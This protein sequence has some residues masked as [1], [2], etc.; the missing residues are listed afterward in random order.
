MSVFKLTNMYSI[1][2]LERICVFQI[3]V[4]ITSLVVKIKHITG[5]L[6]Q[7]FVC[8]HIIFLTSEFFV[9]MFNLFRFCMC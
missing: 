2:N 9:A 7:K 4:I 5:F 6:V 1:P 3:T 8:K